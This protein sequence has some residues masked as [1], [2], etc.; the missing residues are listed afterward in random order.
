MMTP[1]KWFYDSRLLSLLFTVQMWVQMKKFTLW[2]V[3]I[4]YFKIN[5]SIIR[6]DKV[7]F[8]SLFFYNIPIIL[9]HFQ[10]L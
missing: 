9:G 10:N 3:M 5:L 7:D 2:L 8:V 4:N 6:K 1:E